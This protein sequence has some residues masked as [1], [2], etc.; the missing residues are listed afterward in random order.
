MEKFHSYRINPVERLGEGAFGYVEKIEL[1]NHF[2]EICGLYARKVLDPK[3]NILSGMP[4]D[5]VKRRFI[6]EVLYQSEC[7][8]DNVISI[9]LFN[10]YVE[11]PY[12]I[13]DLGICDLQSEI[14]SGGLTE[15]EKIN[16]L[17]MILYGMKK[18]HDKNYLHRDIKPSNIVR[19]A[20]GN[21]KISDFG[22]VKNVDNNSDTTALT[23]IGVQMG[24]RKY[25]APEIL[26]DSEYSK[27]TDIYAVGVVFDEL[28]ISNAN[29]KKII[30]KCK[31][32]DKE[33]RYNCISEIIEDVENIEEK[34]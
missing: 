27:Q 4:H 25:M 7:V 8:H 15:E 11:N 21:Y 24:T 13:M 22:L 14:K 2:D 31:S 18:I 12:F 6:R 1:Y 33:N 28:S 19:F 17:K 32:I 23:A 9:C 34:Q 5:E 26:Y 30:L 16:I 20:N 3:E 10:K 29:Y